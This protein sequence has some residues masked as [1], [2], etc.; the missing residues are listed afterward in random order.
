M[1]ARGVTPEGPTV[2]SVTTTRFLRTDD[3]DLS[4]TVTIGMQKGG[5]SKSTMTAECGHAAAR[6]G[7][8]VLLIDFDP[9]WGLTADQLGYDPAPVGEEPDLT[10]AELLTNV[11]DGGAADALLSAPEKWDPRT[12]LSW[13]RGGTLT[14]GGALAFI[15]GYPTLQPAVEGAINVPAAE[16]RLR[17]AL[18][19]VAQQFDLVLIDTG[20][21]ADKVAQTALLAAGTTIAPVLPE[22]GSV[23]GLRDQLEFLEEF[24][25]GWEHPIRFAGAICSRFDRGAPKAHGDGM[26][27]LRRALASHR[28]ALPAATGQFE[29]S[30]VEPAQFNG[31]V[32]GLWDEVVSK[33]TALVN[34]LRLHQPLSTL[35]DV[36]DESSYHNRVL[37][38]RVSAITNVY[39]RI[40]LRLLQL[41][42]APC[43]PK[44]AD[45]IA[46][47]PLPGVWPMAEIAN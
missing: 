7:A 41:T 24:A 9:N 34:S 12:D 45:Q 47:H 33:S 40:A 27:D 15:P 32:G 5:T 8:R 4:R 11:R 30:G 10:V 37:A 18:R 21:R 35:L 1:P 43:L 14:D 20:P 22:F 17:R 39:S 36:T 25:A 38:E 2:L 31:T 28:S 6:L 29:M 26:D 19:G 3:P 16:R 44:I 23:K 46:A 42:E 13:E